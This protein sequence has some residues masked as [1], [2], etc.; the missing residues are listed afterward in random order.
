MVGRFRTEALADAIEPI[1]SV[2]RCVTEVPLS[3]PPQARSRGLA[4]DTDFTL[5]LWGNKPVPLRGPHALQFAVAHVV[6]LVQTGDGEPGRILARPV[7]Y[8]YRV[9]EKDGGEILAYQWT[10]SAQPPERA[11]P[12]LHIGSLVTSGSDFLPKRFNRLHLPTG[13][14]SLAAVIRFLIEELEVEPIIDRAQAI[15]RLVRS[16]AAFH[17]ARSD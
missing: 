13:P 17:Q 3:V 8:H 1:Q 4:L 10:P 14:V 15:D 12:H 16:D 5:T 6:R 9:L 7:L 11:Y 2:V